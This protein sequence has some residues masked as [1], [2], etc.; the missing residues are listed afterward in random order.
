MV[1]DGVLATFIAWI[2]LVHRSY[3]IINLSQVVDRLFDPLF[4]FDQSC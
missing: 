2:T 4:K 3:P 1:Q